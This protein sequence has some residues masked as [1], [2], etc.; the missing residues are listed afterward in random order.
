MT[1]QPTE[2][3]GQLPKTDCFSLGSQNLSGLDRQL[4]A[5]YSALVAGT[6]ALLLREDCGNWSSGFLL[7]GLACFLVGL[8]A[9][10]IHL[11]VASEILTI[12][13]WMQADVHEFELPNGTKL[14]LAEKM[15]NLQR[16]ST[17]A[18]RA[19]IGNFVN[20]IFWAGVGFIILLFG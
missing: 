12:M 17:R 13:G 20:G 3:A 16:T 4:L 6:V 8:T 19:V 14:D 15:K 9:T 10:V 2:R 1:N 11:K 7:V 5:I 18:W